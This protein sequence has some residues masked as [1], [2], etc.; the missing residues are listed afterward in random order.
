MFQGKVCRPLAREFGC[1][2]E[3]CLNIGF[4]NSRIASQDFRDGYASGKVVQNDGNHHARAPDA[5]PPMTDDRVDRDNAPA[6]GPRLI[7]PLRV[8]LSSGL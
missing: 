3:S 4:L 5:S 8:S 1:V 7:L 6:T 2:G